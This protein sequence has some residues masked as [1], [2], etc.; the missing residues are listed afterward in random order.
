MRK[1]ASPARKNGFLRLPRKPLTRGIFIFM[2]MFQVGGERPI[3]SL[4]LM[5][6]QSV[7]CAGAEKF[8]SFSIIS[9]FKSVYSVSSP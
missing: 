4:R 8:R 7:T 2:A 6:G 5:A 9:V 3:I 1:A